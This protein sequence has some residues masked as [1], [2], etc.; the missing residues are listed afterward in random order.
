MENA[1]KNKASSI[2]AK[3]Q[4]WTTSQMK[5]TQASQKILSKKDMMDTIMTSDMLR[6]EMQQCS[7]NTSG[8]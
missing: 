3:S 4:D 5:L 8:T 7:A 1:I 2:H 6:R